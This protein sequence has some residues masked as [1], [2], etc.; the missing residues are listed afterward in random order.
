[1]TTCL[2]QRPLSFYPSSCLVGTH[3]SILFS[4]AL[5]S[6]SVVYP[7]STLSRVCI[8]HL[9]CRPLFL[10]RS[11]SVFNTFPGMCFS[12][13][14]VTCHYQFKYSIGRGVFWN[15]AP[16]SL[17]NAR[18]VPDLVTRHV[19]PSDFLNVMHISVRRYSHTYI[20][21][22]SRNLPH[23]FNTCFAMPSFQ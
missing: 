23:F 18:F 21:T 5:S 13:L 3:L 17:S 15:H 10:F 2:S 14:L 12:S 19:L 9:S 11:L 7:S 16:L 6:F 1:M 4:V 22:V 8:F 20:Y